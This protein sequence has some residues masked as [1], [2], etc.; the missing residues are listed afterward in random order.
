[1]ALVVDLSGVVETLEGAKPIFPGRIIHRVPI[2]G[3][4]DSFYEGGFFGLR[5]SGSERGT[6]NGA[7]FIR[8]HEI[9]DR[10]LAERKRTFWEWV[11]GKTPGV[12]SW[13]FST[14]DVFSH[15]GSS[16]FDD[17]EEEVFLR[18]G[19]VVR[20]DGSE[21]YRNYLKALGSV[22]GGVTISDSVLREV[23]DPIE[24]E[25]VETYERINSS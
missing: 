1:M 17:L 13:N 22:N 25:L 11:A 18:G 19:Q 23:F 4:E 14:Y 9:L 20:S 7:A 3:R 10:D 5:E 21:D 8:K 16:I 12:S 24:R 2:V 15:V 6:V